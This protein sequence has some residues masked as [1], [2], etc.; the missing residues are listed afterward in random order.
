MECRDAK[1]THGMG[2]REVLQV[3]TGLFGLT[4]FDFLGSSGN[5]MGSW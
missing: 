5:L 2:R 4:L 3:G 1:Q